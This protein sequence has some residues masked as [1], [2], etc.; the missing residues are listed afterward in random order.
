MIATKI[1]S[2]KFQFQSFV[3]LVVVVV[4]VANKSFWINSQD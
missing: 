3:V 1:T 2:Q 4:V